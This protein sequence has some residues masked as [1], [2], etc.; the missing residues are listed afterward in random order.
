MGGYD[1]QGSDTTIGSGGDIC[2]YGVRA[3]YIPV[4]CGI[5]DTFTLDGEGT[6]ADED[7]IFRFH[8]RGGGTP[9]VALADAVGRHICWLADSCRCGGYSGIGA[10]PEGE[11]GDVY[12]EKSFDF[13]LVFVPLHRRSA[14]AEYSVA[15]NFGKLGSNF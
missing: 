12:V 4:V 5:C 8:H 3:T 6:C 11:S 14:A 7:N 1:T 10:L 13:A 15:V 9:A 2:G